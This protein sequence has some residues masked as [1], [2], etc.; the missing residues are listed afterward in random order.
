MMKKPNYLMRCTNAVFVTIAIIWIF[1]YLN[2][3]LIDI[4][5][6]LYMPL[7][8]TG[9]FLVILTWFWFVVER[10]FRDL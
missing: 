10:I 1:G 2:H 4:Y 5:S 3:L 6:W 7:N 8:L 9:A